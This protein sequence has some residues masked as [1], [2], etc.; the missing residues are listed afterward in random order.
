VLLTDVN[1]LV[2]ASRV[3]LPEHGRAGLRW[4][5]PLDG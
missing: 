4:R 3:D 5:H 2:Y 1:V